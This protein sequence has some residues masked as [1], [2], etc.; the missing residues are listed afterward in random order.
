VI[1][2]AGGIKLLIGKVKELMNLQ[3]TRKKVQ[4]EGEREIGEERCHFR[5]AVPALR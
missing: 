5:W 1:K 4:S 2:G 3:N